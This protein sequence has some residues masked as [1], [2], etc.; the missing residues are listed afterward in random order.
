MQGFSFN[1]SWT[2]LTGIM[3]QYL[4]M[5]FQSQSFNVFAEGLACPCI[6]P[7]SLT[8]FVPPFCPALFSVLSC[9]DCWPLF[10]FI[11]ANTH[12]RTDASRPQLSR[13]ISWSITELPGICP[14]HTN[15]GSR[16]TEGYVGQTKRTQTNGSKAVVEGQLGNYTHLKVLS[17]K[18]NLITCVKMHQDKSQIK[19]Y[20]D[21]NFAAYTLFP[22]ENCTETNRHFTACPHNW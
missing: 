20:S 7:Y 15:S 1:L 2:K 17:L 5:V 12:T 3:L 22:D 4:Q 18:R 14:D 16:V 11:W 6:H 13:L 19:M 21:W 10:C 9:C 8:P